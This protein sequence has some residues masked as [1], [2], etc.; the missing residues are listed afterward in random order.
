M[1]RG[2]SETS[3][4]TSGRSRFSR[5]SGLAR[6]PAADTPNALRMTRDMPV[7]RSRG[8]RCC[9]VDPNEGLPAAEAA[10]LVDHFKLLADP[11]R[12]QILDVLSRNEGQVCVCDLEA[13]VPVKQ[14]TVSHHLKVL[15][16]AGVVETERRGVWAYYFVNRARLEELRRDVAAFLDGV[17][18]VERD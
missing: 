12:L 1:I 14:P 13:A 17:A 18:G 6:T 7:T 4:R 16:N 15:R 10:D 5:E 2:T 9:E 11:V 3:E 8:E